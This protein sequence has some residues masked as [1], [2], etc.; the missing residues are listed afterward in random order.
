MILRPPT[1][2]VLLLLE[3]KRLKNANNTE[4]VTCRVQIYRGNR[5]LNQGET[6]VQASHFSQLLPHQKE[7]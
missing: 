1:V 5:V 2:L 7:Q 4:M 3:Y 6:Y